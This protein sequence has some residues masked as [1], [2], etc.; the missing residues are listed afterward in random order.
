[1]KGINAALAIGTGVIMALVGVKLFGIFGGPGYEMMDD[2][3]RLALI[4]LLK[5]PGGGI[6]IATYIDDDSES[7]R[8]TAVELM[9]LTGLNSYELAVHPATSTL[10]MSDFLK[11]SNVLQ[12]EGISTS[13][14]YVLFSNCQ[15]W[16]TFTDPLMKEFTAT[17]S[18][19]IGKY[20][21]GLSSTATNPD[22]VSSHLNENWG[23]AQKLCGVSCI[24]AEV[25]AS[26]ADMAKGFRKTMDMN[27]FE[28]AQEI[29]SSMR[30]KGC[31]ESCAQVCDSVYSGLKALLGF[32]MEAK[33]AFILS[34]IRLK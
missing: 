4:T 1:M 21:A 24:N 17:D 10:E 26:C 11:V 15:Q 13:F 12:D 6:K 19:I 31:G 7:V 9:E 5:A 25:C 3:A 23:D 30:L 29:E 27:E 2:T 20:Y 18:R 34:G 33:K 32:D 22:K 16:L 28:G 14:S 8:N